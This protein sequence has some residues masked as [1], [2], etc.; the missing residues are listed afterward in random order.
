[1]HPELGSLGC[2]GGSAKP[3]RDSGSFCLITAVLGSQPNTIIWLLGFSHL[4]DALAQEKEEGYRG[5]L[6][7]KT[8]GAQDTPM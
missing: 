3:F 6:H 1:M 5:P 2:C 7:P 4:V 8:P